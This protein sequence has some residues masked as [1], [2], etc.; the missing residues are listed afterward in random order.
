MA[1]EGRGGCQDSKKEF[2]E[3]KGDEGERWRGEFK[4]D[5]FDIL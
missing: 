5:A 1:R 2:T 3:G 4:Y